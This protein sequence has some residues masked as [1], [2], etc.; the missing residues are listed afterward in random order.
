MQLQRTRC[1][2]YIYIPRLLYYYECKLVCFQQPDCFTPKRQLPRSPL[3]PYRSPRAISEG[4]EKEPVNVQDVRFTPT[5]VLKRSPVAR[6]K[7]AEL[8]TACIA[9]SAQTD[10]KQAKSSSLGI[11]AGKKSRERTRKAPAKPAS[12][13]RRHAT[14]ERTK[15][16]RKTQ[17]AC[18][19]P[20]KALTCS[21]TNKRR[22]FG[23]EQKVRRVVTDPPMQEVRR[24]VTDPWP[25]IPSK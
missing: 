3:R 19:T 24:V 1:D 21:P 12:K 9:A 5:H 13:T 8:K 22:A 10:S 2:R 23:E 25:P 18:F 17:A 16:V 7:A 4:S 20:T 15:D 6:Q 14:S 11:V